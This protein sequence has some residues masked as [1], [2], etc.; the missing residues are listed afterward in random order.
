MSRN[1]ARTPTTSRLGRMIGIFLL[2]NMLPLG[3]GGWLLFRH[4]RGDL[5]PIELPEGSTFNLQA[6]AACLL[7]LI[8]VASLS[9]PVAHRIVKRVEAA[10]RW[11][12]DGL[13]LRNRRA[14][15]P[16]LLGLPFLALSW[17][18]A[19]LVRLVLL[20][21]ALALILLTILFVARLFE[22]DL[23]QTQVDAV[24]KWRPGS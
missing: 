5:P 3:V 8:L 17:I 22:P 19:A 18:V 1:R 10:L 14:F 21:L 9:L 13:L 12:R 7:A 24:L 23:L 4:L 2:V 16:A 20:L 6:L 11:A 15:F